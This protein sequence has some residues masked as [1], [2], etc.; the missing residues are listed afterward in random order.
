MKYEEDSFYIEKVLN[1]DASA[2]EPLV[3]KYKNYVF[4]ATYKI[5]GSREDAEE[6]SQDVFM[7]AYRS[8]DSYRSESKFSTW[9]YRIAFN[10]AVSK[11]RKKTLDFKEID[12]DVVENVFAVD[13][14]NQIDELKAEEQK[15]YL[16]KALKMLAEDE[17][18]I[19]TLYH[20]EEQSI[21]EI[22]EITGLT[23]TNVKT[24][25]HRGRKKLYDGLEKLL[26]SEVRSIV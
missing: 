18:N 20:L 9:L 6:V 25:L 15:L 22:C 5:V 21:D 12:Q 17:A 8:L 1:G 10:A 7:K 23:N 3:N 14:A 11:T 19:I 2:F 16:G 26:Q 4:S 24:K 13:V